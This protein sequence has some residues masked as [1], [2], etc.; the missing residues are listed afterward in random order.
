[1]T[2][3]G[4]ADLME[5]I[6]FRDNEPVTPVFE[7]NQKDIKFLALKNSYLKTIGTYRVISIW[8]HGKEVAFW[9]KKDGSSGDR[10]YPVFN[11]EVDFLAKK[12]KFKKN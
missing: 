3:A 4:F 7:L 9:V 10:L 6:G 5:K 11:E 12:M 1:M 2:F 8:S